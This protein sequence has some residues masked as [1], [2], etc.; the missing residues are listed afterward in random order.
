METTMHDELPAVSS[1]SALINIETDR[2]YAHDKLL[3]LIMEWTIEP[4][5]LV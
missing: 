5:S 3:A 1:G 4:K 2:T